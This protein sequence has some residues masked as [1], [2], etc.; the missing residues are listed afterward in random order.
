MFHQPSSGLHQ[1]LLQAGQGPVLNPS[2]QTQPPPQ[3]PQVVGQQA[4]RQPHLV[5]AEPMAREPRH[6]DRLL[7]LLD[8]LLRRPPLVIEPHHRLGVSRLVTMKPNRG[9]NS[10]A[11]YS[12]FATTRRAVFQL[13]AW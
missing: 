8:P 3:I 5:R 2:R 7:S 9:N 6:L 11:W 1:P 10:P 4:Q 12:T 13:A